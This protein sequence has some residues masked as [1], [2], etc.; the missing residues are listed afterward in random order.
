MPGETLPNLGDNTFI[1]GTVRVVA[2]DVAVTNVY[3]MKS[4]ASQGYPIEIYV[5][6][7]NEGTTSEDF[8]VTAYYSSVLFQTQRVTGLAPGA[9]RTLTFTWNANVP[10]GDYVLSATAEYIPGET[11][12][13][14]N[15]FTDDT[16]RIKLPGDVDG[17]G[18]VDVTDLSYV[19]RA[20]GSDPRWPWGNDW[21]QWNENCDFNNDLKC[22]V[23][24]LSI[25][26]ENYGAGG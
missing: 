23:W 14:D 21:Y 7:R 11:D 24:D 18:D 2:H 26:V 6:V 12:T 1:D 20:F 16:I 9:S 22:D 13:A 3:P 19:A 17:D 5:E 10:L 15:S 4:S 25:G 8:D